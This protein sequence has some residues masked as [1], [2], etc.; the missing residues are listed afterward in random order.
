MQEVEGLKRKTTATG[1]MGHWYNDYT[2]HK[3]V[4]QKQIIS[5][6]CDASGLPDSLSTCLSWLR[7]ACHATV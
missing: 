2:D 7:T 1:Q 5:K 3:Y 4:L 6:Y